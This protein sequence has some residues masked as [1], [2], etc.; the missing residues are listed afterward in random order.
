M[1]GFDD[2]SYNNVVN[3]KCIVNAATEITTTSTVIDKL[4]LHMSFPQGLYSVNTNNGNLEDYNGIEGVTFEIKYRKVGDTPWNI[5]QGLANDWDYIYT[6]E[7]YTYV[8]SGGGSNDWFN[9]GDSDSGNW[10]FGGGYDD[11]GY[12]DGYG[13]ATGGGW[14]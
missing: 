10:G 3:S 1:S 11:G 9:G 4:N 12:S 2:S 13:D 6:Y 5:L 7:Q 14:A 8:D